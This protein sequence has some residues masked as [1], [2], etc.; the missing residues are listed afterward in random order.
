MK[1]LNFKSKFKT[2]NYYWWHI[3]AIADNNSVFIE[4]SNYGNSFEYD[5]DNKE[6]Y[7]NILIGD[8]IYIIECH[9]LGDLVIPSE[10]LK[11]LSSGK[12]I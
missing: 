1:N 2:Q 6:F 10:L 11:L 3:R 12:N 8:K 4:E 9:G 5:I 7:G